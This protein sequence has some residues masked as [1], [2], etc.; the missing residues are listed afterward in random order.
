MYRTHSST[1]QNN[2]GDKDWLKHQLFNDDIR[3]DDLFHS[4]RERRNIFLT[5][6]KSLLDDTDYNLD[7]IDP[8]TESVEDT[9]I[10]ENE[11][12]I[13]TTPKDDITDLNEESNP[14]IYYLNLRKKR[15]LQD[16][17]NHNEEN[18]KNRKEKCWWESETTT[19]APVTTFVKTFY[20]GITTP[21]PSTM[22]IDTRTFH[23]GTSD[24]TSPIRKKRSVNVDLD[25]KF[26]SKKYDEKTEI[27][28][29][30]ILNQF[31]EIMRWWKFTQTLPMIPLRNQEQSKEDTTEFPIEFF[32]FEKNSDIKNPSNQSE[33]GTNNK[34]KGCYCYKDV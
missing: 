1:N 5:K 32:P 22:A 28:K 8:F 14:M 16:Q 15:H 4:R 12:D 26:K 17:H 11:D 25:N 6:P 23:V 20:F 27:E 21:G 34:R 2:I 9:S 13:T 29:I 31:N 33:D 30:K 18:T 19:P 7:T 24:P 3:I 10:F